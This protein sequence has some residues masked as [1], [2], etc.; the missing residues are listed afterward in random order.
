M[1]ID[2]VLCA[3]WVFLVNTHRAGLLQ[4]VILTFAFMCSVAGYVAAKVSKIQIQMVA[5]RRSD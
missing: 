4:S 2:P 5:F 1:A 3:V